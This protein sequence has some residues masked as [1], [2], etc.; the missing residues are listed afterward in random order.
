[1]TPSSYGWAALAGLILAILIT[2]MIW[3]RSG[4][5]QAVEASEN[6]ARGDDAARK[7]IEHEAVADV[8][9]RDLP[10]G[11]AGPRVRDVPGKLGGQASGPGGA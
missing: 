5:R 9:R 6:A 2:V 3:V 10:G 11:V 1:M 7:A 8:E 4:K